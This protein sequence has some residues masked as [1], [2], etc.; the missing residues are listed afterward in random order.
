MALSDSFGTEQ[1]VAVAVVVAASTLVYYLTRRKQDPYASFPTPTGSWPYIGHLACFDK[2]AGFKFKDWHDAFGP[3]LRIQMGVQPWI[4]C[5]DHKVLHTLFVTNGIN[6]SNRPFQTFPSHYYALGK[7]GFSLS[8]PNKKWKTL[9]AAALSVLSPKSVESFSPI[10]QSEADILINDLVAGS[11]DGNSVNPLP[12]VHRTSLNYV[13]QTGFGFRI[14]SHEEKTFKMVIKFIVDGLV[15]SAPQNDLGGFL[16]VLSFVDVLLGRDKMF[17]ESLG[18]VRDPLFRE[19]L[20]K[21]ANSDRDCLF[22]RLLEQREEHELDHEDVVVAAGDIVAGGTDT[23]AASVNWIF[24]ILLHHPE[25]CRQISAELDA[26]IREHNRLPRFA[27]R[28]ALP[29][30]ISVQKECMRYKGVFLIAPFH[31]LEKDIQCHGYLFPKGAW[32]MPSIYAIHRNPELYPEPDTFIPERFLNNTQ[33]MQSAANG[34]LEERDHFSFGFGRRVCP[35]IHLA[36]VQMFNILI[37]VF[38]YC[39]LEKPLSGAVPD[40]DDVQDAGV[41]AMP[42]AYEARFVR[43]PDALLPFPK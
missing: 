32:I 43:R 27:E 25:T 22:K 39:T 28:D 26:F 38:A 16:P 4:I 17:R 14:V 29:F 9:R 15:N 6:A 3:V 31:S 40:L 7:R 12:L 8:D 13:L 24:A 30:L 23:T 19:L 34:R 42:P 10:H 41:T 21:A 33:T 36:E 5:S 35:G 18:T 37:R 11:A 20:D 1:T 2:I